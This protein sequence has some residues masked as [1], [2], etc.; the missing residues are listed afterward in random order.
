MV[1]GHSRPSRFDAMGGGLRLG[2]NECQQARRLTCVSNDGRVK[3]TQGNE[4][5][6]TNSRTGRRKKL[7]ET[8]IARKAA[9]VQVARPERPLNR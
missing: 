5:A 8:P 4:A 7:R 3:S 6:A 9:K 1:G 2:N